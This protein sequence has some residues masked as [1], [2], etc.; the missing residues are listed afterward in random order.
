MGKAE[1]E[2]YKA[3]EACAVLEA[4]ERKRR[5]NPVSTDPYA[6]PTT[7]RSDA[8]ELRASKAPSMNYLSVG[9]QVARIVVF[10][11]IAAFLLWR[12]KQE[13][14]QQSLDGLQQ[15]IRDEL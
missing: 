10:F 5:E 9:I 8:A 11:G 7:S 12:R 14:E 13:R 2:Q 4:A 15:E 6:L 1:R 3:E